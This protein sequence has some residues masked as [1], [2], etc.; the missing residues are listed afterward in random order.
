MFKSSSSKII[1]NVKNLIFRN[2][3][4]KNSFL[5]KKL[6]TKV[7]EKIAYLEVEWNVHKSHNVGV[8]KP[9]TTRTK[10]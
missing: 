5:N 9:H 1:V 3:I 2:G 6:D 10:N 8:H 7:I 4:E